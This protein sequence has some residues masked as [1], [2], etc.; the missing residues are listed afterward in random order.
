MKRFF[1]PVFIAVILGATGAFV[2]DF[3]QNEKVFN[4]ELS[5]GTIAGG[6][7]SNEKEVEDSLI[8]LEPIGGFKEKITKKY[9]GLFITPQ[10][11]PVQPDKFDGY[12]NGVDVEYEGILQ[13]I[14]VR[15]ITDGTVVFSDW[16]KGYGGVMVLNHTIDGKDYFVLYGHLDPQSM[17]KNN[18]KVKAGDII[19][20][21][22]N[23]HS[24]ETD[25]ARKHLHFS[26]RPV[27]NGLD[28]RGYVKTEE[29]L[30]QWIDPLTLYQ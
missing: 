7:D 11:S 26:V 2:F 22:G 1:L 24:E 12:H 16:V 25:G 19:G 28:F 15:A 23:D 30:A 13:E 27:E 6:F 9:F 29:E 21:L 14:S 8:I 17:I 5:S 10:T 4:I 20:V 18:I 3:A